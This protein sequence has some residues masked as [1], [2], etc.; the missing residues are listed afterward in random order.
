MQAHFAS[1][2]GGVAL[3]IAT[4]APAP[5]HAVDTALVL[6]FATDCQ[7]DRR[8]TEGVVT[9]AKQLYQVREL[10]TEQVLAPLKAADAVAAACPQESGFLLGG[11]V[12]KL[13]QGKRAR[14]WALHGPAGSQQP[15]VMDVYCDRPG[16]DLSSQLDK[17]VW[18]V[19]NHQTPPKDVQPWSSRPTFCTDPTAPPIEKM[20]RSGK[21]VLAV[22]GDKL[23]KGLST[24]LSQELKYKKLIAAPKQRLGQDGLVALLEGDSKGQVLLIEHS[25]E[26]TAISVFDVLTK[27]TYQEPKLVQCAGCTAD[28]LIS[29]ITESAKDHLAHCFD[30][31][32]PQRD[33]K[34]VV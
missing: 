4:S 19:S 6:P 17:A 16:C 24:E 25:A 31:E 8:L 23:P 21:V 34:S 13:A 1:A 33:R 27:Q 22:Y 30:K 12:Q 10:G 20:E 5:A 15:V 9:A 29:K 18:A 11:Y 7:P 3:L 14:V 28:R 26:A 32:C 2:L